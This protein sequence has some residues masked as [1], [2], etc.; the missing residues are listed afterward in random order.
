MAG[1]RLALKLRLTNL[2]PHTGKVGN[3]SY[4]TISVESITIDEFLRSQGNPEIHFIKMDIE[5]AEPKA[6]QGMSQT[7]HRS[8]FLMMVVECS[9]KNLQLG[10]ISVS[11]FVRQLQAMGFRVQA[12]LPDG[13]RNA[14]DESVQKRAA[15]GYVNLFCVKGDPTIYAQSQKDNHMD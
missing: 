12:I 2:S 4:H 15:Q 3:L 11:V 10:N 5:G 7:V 13:L 9:A 1:S 6:L 14:L 8:K